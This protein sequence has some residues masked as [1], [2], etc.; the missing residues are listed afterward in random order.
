MVNPEPVFDFQHL[1]TIASFGGYS[2]LVPM[3]DAT[4]LL[5]LSALPFIENRKFWSTPEQ[6]ISDAN[7]EIVVEQINIAMRNLMAN[8]AIG[9]FFYSL[10][11]LT[12]P[13]VII[14]IGQLIAQTDYAEFTAV[15]PAGW[16]VGSDIQLPDMRETFIMGG[17]TPSSLG[18]LRG[19]NVH[20]LDVSEIPSHNHSQNPHSHT[21]VIPLVTPVG[22]VP[23][24]PTPN[25]VIGTP[26][27]TGLASGTNNP[28]GG[29]QDHNNVPQSMQ[30]VPYIV[31]R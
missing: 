4:N 18:V 16:L 1:A 23:V 28:T 6:P 9:T 20:N 13:S 27:P 17:N 10:A 14:P 11:I 7:Y 8:Y 12:D 15:V 5:L 31:V 22:A 25:V 26:S 21:T 3:S 30:L 24:P 29:G 19:S 2:N